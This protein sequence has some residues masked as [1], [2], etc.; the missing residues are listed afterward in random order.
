MP[1]LEGTDDRPEPTYAGTKTTIK[2][3]EKV[4]AV[5][6][7]GYGLEGRKETAVAEELSLVPTKVQTPVAPL[8]SS[9]ESG[10]ATDEAEDEAKVGRTEHGKSTKGRKQPG[11]SSPAD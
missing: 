8:S 10:S 6:T 1:S 2:E 9:A 11:Q 5:T 3:A 7:A 4:F